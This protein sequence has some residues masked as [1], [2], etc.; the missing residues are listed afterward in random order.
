MIVIS[1]DGVGD[2]EFKHLA[3]NPSIYPN[4]AAFKAASHYRGNVKS[5]F[6][7]NTYPVHTT[8]ATGKLPRDHG[9]ISNY[10]DASKSRRWA[11][12]TS[13]IKAKTIWDAAREK[14]LSVASIFWPVTCNANIRWNMPEVHA[15]KKR[16]QL[17]E[18][19]RY[20]SRG[21]QI[22]AL[23]RH[24]FRLMRFDVIGLDDFA[25]AVACDLLRKKRADLILLHLL[26]YDITRHRVGGQA[27]ELDA[28]R[29]S[30]DNSL[31]KIMDAAG[32]RAIL[33]FAD[34]AHLDVFETVD[35][36][37]I[38][39]ANLYE[40]CGGSAFLRNTIDGIDK[41]P[42]FGRFLTQSE[43]ASSGYAKKS[44]CGIA[45]KIGYCFAD[46]PVKSNH[47]YPVDY[48]KYKTF[49]AIRDKHMS[50]SAVPVFGDV[51]DIT[52]IIAQKLGLDLATYD[53]GA[54][55]IR[56]RT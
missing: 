54:D 39:G 31:G 44:Q 51:R 15:L 48:A 22:G 35:L 50:D 29:K 18:N 38:F 4:I 1:F 9:I 7:S 30:L 20:G 13:G 53:V 56:L 43:M 52:A 34:H 55:T 49:Y 12:M 37:R 28:A 11:Q 42:W 36:R 23:L 16:N 21:F 46:K 3:C 33:V 40:Q 14:G 19:L 8:I 17:A 5:V 32:E 47:G 41:H 24:G 26:V 45:A 27:N 25:S 6:V 10:V 2:E